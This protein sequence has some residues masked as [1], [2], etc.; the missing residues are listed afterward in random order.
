MVDGNQYKKIYTYALDFLEK[1]KPEGVNLEPYYQADSKCTS[2]E[3]VFE[4]FVISAQ[5]YQS[6]PNVI[7][8]TKNKDRK[9]KIEKLLRNYDIAY[10]S[11]LDADELYRVFRDEFKITSND[12]KLN[13]WS[14]WSHAIVD[15]AKFLSEFNSY[16]DFD[17]FVNIFNYNVHT[18]MALPLLI[19][20]KVNGIGFALACDMLK[21]LGYVN[22]PKPDVHLMDVFSELGLCE[23]EPLPTFET[24]VK[25]AEVCE[26]TP[27]KVDKVFWLICS[28]R[29]YK[30]EA[31]NG[32]IKPLKKKFIDEVKEI[33]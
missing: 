8:V 32:K 29:F 31:E 16:D 21:E 6:M 11:T 1:N 17:E 26:E 4:R 3:G 20:E 27:Y 24:A 13:S 18:R 7:G 12:S 5:N 30:E 15:S 19:A 33:M 22:Y 2:L 9:D 28:G 25:I 10:V 14:K 23:H